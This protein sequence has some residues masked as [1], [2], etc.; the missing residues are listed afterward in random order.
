[1]KGRWN[2][3]KDGFLTDSFKTGS[4]RAKNPYQIGAF[5]VSEGGLELPGQPASEIEL[6]SGSLRQAVDLGL[7][8]LSL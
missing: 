4:R 6:V 5:V 3:T 1:M 7:K 2:G 8:G